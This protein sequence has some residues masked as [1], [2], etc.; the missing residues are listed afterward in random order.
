MATIPSYQV[1]NVVLSHNKWLSPSLVSCVFT[2]E[3][4]GMMKMDGPDQRIKILF[5]SVNGVA[6]ALTAT[7]DWWEQI[8]ALPHEQRPTPRTYTLRHVNAAKCLMEVEFVVHGTEGPAS[9]WVIS[10]KP[11]DALQIVAPNKQHTADSGGYEWR[12][13]SRVERALVVADETALPAVKGILEQTAKMSVPPLLQIFQEVPLT[14][15]CLDWREYAFA[16][17]FW[18]PRDTTKTPHGA[19]LLHAVKEHVHIPDDALS[20]DQQEGREVEDDVLWHGAEAE[21][22]RFY[23]WI[24]A[25][26]SA[27]KHIRRY[28]VRE[29]HVA[30]EN[31]SFMA[32]WS[33]VY[34]F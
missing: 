31:V 20:A 26:S 11:G 6:S 3:E 19:A 8:K 22:S 2:G 34:P 21:G 23:G 15:D 18:L 10:A 13:G 4:V 5:P 17:V 7:G 29:R 9:A 30:S 24:A 16:E 25:E 12:P 14:E 32:Y 28:L 33:R 27:V 1:F